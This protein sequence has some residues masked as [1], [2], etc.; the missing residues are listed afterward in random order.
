MARSY[1]GE[2]RRRGLGSRRQRIGPILARLA[3]EHADATIDVFLSWYPRLMRPLVRQAIYALLDEPLR[4]TFGYPAPAPLV[5]PLTRGG[6][7]LAARI[8]RLLPPRRK[9]YSRTQDRN[10]TYPKGYR[11]ETLGATEPIAK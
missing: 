10:R 7:K 4:A 1:V 8:I 6:L 9:P 3:R 5:Q 11:I 2:A